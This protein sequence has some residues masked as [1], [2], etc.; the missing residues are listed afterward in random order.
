MNPLFKAEVYQNRRNQLKKAVK[1]GIAIFLGNSEAPMNYPSNTYNPYT[2]DLFSQVLFATS[3]QHRTC[4]WLKD[5]S[6]QAVKNL[7]VLP[8]RR[9]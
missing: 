8:L 5:L 7:V 1:S 3:L 9:Y 6:L 4:I 2:L